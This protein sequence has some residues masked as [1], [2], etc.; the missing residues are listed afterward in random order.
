MPKFK[1][2]TF[3]LILFSAGIGMAQAQIKIPNPA[4]FKKDMLGAMIPGDDINL[5]SD[6]KDVLKKQNESFVSNVLQIA[7]GDQSEDKKIQAIKD[8]AGKNSSALDKIFGDP[9]LAKQ[10]KKK[11]KKKIQPF[12]RKYKLATLIL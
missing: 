5:S 7:N 12:K 4:D 2:L 10:Y 6:Q 9:S 8:L 1:S 3:L 11:V